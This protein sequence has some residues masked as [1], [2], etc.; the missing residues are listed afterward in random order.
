MTPEPLEICDICGEGLYG[1]SHYHCGQCHS[2]DVTGMMG[3]HIFDK[4][5]CDPDERAAWVRENMKK[6][7]HA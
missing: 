6:L 4:T 1:G 5:V 3:H 2:I 7:R